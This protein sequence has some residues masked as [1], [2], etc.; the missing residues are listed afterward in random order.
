[1]ALTLKERCN[2]RLA[3]LKAARLPFED[4]WREIARYAQPSRSRFLNSEANRNFKRSNRAIYNSHAILA[5]RTLT[6][7]MTSGLSSPSRPWSGIRR[8]RRSGS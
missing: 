6:G 7:G 2:R 8:A 4:E 5:F 1:M 3:A